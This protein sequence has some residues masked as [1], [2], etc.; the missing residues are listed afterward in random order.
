MKKTSII[1][2]TVMLIGSSAVSYAAGGH[3]ASGV[4]PGHVMQ[5]NTPTPQDRGAAMGASTLTPAYDMKNNN[6]TP[7]APH[8]ASTFAPGNSA[9]G[10]NK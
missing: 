3:G 9:P 6:T 2:A 7:P 5:T 4:A 1:A 10:R 8:G